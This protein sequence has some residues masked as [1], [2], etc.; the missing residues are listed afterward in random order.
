[1]FPMELASGLHRRHGAA[2]SGGDAFP[3]GAPSL[4]GPTYFWR[5]RQAVG[6]DHCTM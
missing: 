2:T 5:R 1:M 3:D 6:I 4:L